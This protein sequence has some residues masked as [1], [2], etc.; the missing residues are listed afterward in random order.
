MNRTPV[1]SSHITSIGYENGV[2]EVQYSTNDIYHYSN[3][4]ESDYLNII[5]SPSIGRALR[6]VLHRGDIVGTL[7]RTDVLS[8]EDIIQV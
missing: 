2:L 4:S 3:V 7:N 6:S 5:M 1:D 8:E